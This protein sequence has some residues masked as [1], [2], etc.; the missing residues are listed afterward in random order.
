MLKL[1]LR[2][3]LLGVIALLLIEVVVGLISETTGG[4]E[5]AVIAVVGILLVLSLRRVW[6]IGTSEPR[7]A[8]T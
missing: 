4:A 3:V 1:L 7:P 8:R 5:K 6:R 2:C